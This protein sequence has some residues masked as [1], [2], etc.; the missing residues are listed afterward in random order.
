MKSNS[1]T[2][3]RNSTKLVIRLNMNTSRLK[4]GDVRTLTRN[5]RGEWSDGE[6]CYF[7]SHLHTPEFCTILE[8]SDELIYSCEIVKD[9]DGS[10]YANLFIN[11]KYTCGLPEYVDYKTLKKAIASKGVQLPNLSELC[12]ERYGRKSYVQINS[13][14]QTRKEAIA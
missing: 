10:Y 7:I 8:Q 3:K 4:I 9:F 5:E 11:G 14:E 2:I 1:N 13:E 6:Y 12:F